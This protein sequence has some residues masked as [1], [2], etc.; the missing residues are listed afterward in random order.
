M[1][2]AVAAIKAAAVTSESSVFLMI[3][4]PKF[5]VAA[6]TFQPAQAKKL[7]FRAV[8]AETCKTGLA[9]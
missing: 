2:D 8:T 4:P 3:F 5:F 1:G 9:T 6:Y 7:R